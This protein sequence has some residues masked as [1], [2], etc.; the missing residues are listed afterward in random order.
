MFARQIE[1]LKVKHDEL[2]YE[3]EE[4]MTKNRILMEENEDL[5]ARIKAND[6]CLEDLARYRE[7]LGGRTVSDI[8]EE[9]A[10]LQQSKERANEEELLE[11]VAVAGALEE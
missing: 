4:Y 5:I 2:G 1:E 9:L 11:V 6:R 10:L 8:K 3:C 7:E